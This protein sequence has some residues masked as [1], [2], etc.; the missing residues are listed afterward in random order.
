M[1]AIRARSEINAAARTWYGTLTCR[2]EMHHALLA[3]ARHREA[4]Q[5]VDFETLGEQEQ[6]TLIAREEGKLITDF[7]KRVRKETSASPRYLMVTEQHK[8]GL[9]HWHILLSEQTLSSPIR[10]TVLERQWTAGFSHW[11]LINAADDADS[12]RRI[13]Y[14]TKYVG[15]SM[16]CRV[17][18]SIGYGDVGHLREENVKSALFK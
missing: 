1:W 10:K 17:R 8:S 6:F 7:L 3:L 16:L 11:R 13:A 14:V 4:M 2:P 9:P 5:G 12:G 18:A 15:K